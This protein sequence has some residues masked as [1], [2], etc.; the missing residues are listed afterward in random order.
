MTLRAAL[1]NFIMDLNADGL[2]EDAHGVYMT[3]AYLAR[4]KRM[5]ETLDRTVGL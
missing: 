1:N 3:E 4:A 5:L 2:G